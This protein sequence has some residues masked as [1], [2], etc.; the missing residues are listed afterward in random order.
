MVVY[1]TEQH[2]MHNFLDMNFYCNNWGL[3]KQMQ[4]FWIPTFESYTK[5]KQLTGDLF[6]N[7]L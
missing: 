3:V 4:L 5:S 6:L 2:I 1:L 7:E